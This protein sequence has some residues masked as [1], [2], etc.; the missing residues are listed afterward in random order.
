MAQ[1]SSLADLGFTDESAPLPKKTD[2]SDL[3]FSDEGAAPKIAG[4]AGELPQPATHPAVTMQPVRVV[5]GRP[6]MG[7]PE[8]NA[9]YDDREA[10]K[11]I[12]T[13]VVNTGKEFVSGIG[14]V[15]DPRNLPQKPSENPDAKP[16]T[17]E[18][19][20]AA[21][22]RVMQGA[23][24]I[25]D[26]GG[27]AALAVG[28]PEL[29]E[30]GGLAMTGDTAALKA[31]GK[32]AVGFGA[33]YGISAGAGKVADKYQFTPEG[34]QLV[35]TVSFFFPTLLG[36]GLAKAGFKGGI[37]VDPEGNVGAAASTPGGKFAAGVRATPEA[38]EA[39]VKVGDTRFTAKVPRGTTPEPP[40]IAAGETP[41]PSGAPETTNPPIPPP[42]GMAERNL[43]QDTVSKVA[44]VIKAAPSEVQG[45]KQAEAHGNL[46]KWIL[47]GSGAFTGPDGKKQTAETPAKADRLATKILD[48]ALDRHDEK[49]EEQNKGM[50]D[51]QVETLRGGEIK[52]VRLPEGS[53]YPAPKGLKKI[54]LDGDSFL[55][56]PKAISKTTLV[57]ASEAGT[58]DEFTAA[59]KTP[60]PKPAESAKPEVSAKGNLMEPVEGG[61]IEHLPDNGGLVFH[62]EPAKAAPVKSAAA[63]PTP[64]PEVAEPETVGAKPLPRDLAGSKPRYG[65]KDKNFELDFEDPRDLAAYTTTQAKPNKAHDRFMDYLRGQFPDDV[66]IR[67]HGQKV[68]DAIKEM[69]KDALPSDGPL[70]ISSQSEGIEHLGF[71][72]EKPAVGK[73]GDMLGAGETRLTV[74]GR[75]TSPFPK[76]DTASNRKAGNT[77]KRVDQW[78]MDNAIAEAKARGDDFNLRQ[79]EANRDRP[80]P[81]DKDSA[82]MYLFDKGSVQATP[83]PFLEPAKV[84]TPLD[85]FEAEGKQP[86]DI[87]RQ[88]WVEL[89]RAHRRTIGQSEES[90]TKAAPFSDYEEYHRDAVKE[91]VKR[92]ESV[93]DRVLADYPELGPNAEDQAALSEVLLDRIREGNMPKDNNALRA[94]VSEYDG[95]PADQARMKEA[96]E[97]MEVAIVQRAREVVEEGKDPKTTFDDL[98]GLY[99]SQPN[100]NIRTTTSIENQAYSTPAPLAFIASELA[101]INAKTR[102]YEPTAGNGMLLIGANPKKVLANELNEGR[103]DAL[104]EQGFKVRHGNALDADV[105]PKSMD[106]VITNPPFGSVKG[107][108][109]KPT[110]VKVDG[111]KVG[112][113]DHLI[114]V[115]ALDAMKD[116]GKASI[117][118]G[119]NKV[120]GGLSTDDR[121]FFNWLYSHY[122]VVSHFEVDGALYARQGANWPV[123]VINIDGRIR[124]DK[125]SPKEGGIER[126]GTWEEVYGQFNKGL[127][128]RVPGEG[129]AGAGSVVER[130]AA[131]DAATVSRPAS[132]APQAGN[133][134][135]PPAGGTVINWEPGAQ[136]ES[137]HGSDVQS[138]SGLASTDNDVRPDAG[139]AR[140][141]ILARGGRRDPPARRDADARR[142]DRG[143]LTAPEN[144]FQVAYTPVSSKK[145]VGIL[146]PKNMRDPLDHAMFK[147]E[148][149]VGDIDEFVASEL[150]YET[151]DDLHDVFMGLQI[152]SVA[153]A[154]HQMRTGKAVVISDM[155]GIGKGR[156][157]A[158]I[159]RWAEKHGKLPIFMTAKAPLFTDIYGDLVDIGSDD[160]RP[161]IVNI[162]EEISLPNG[163]KVFGNTKGTHRA[164]IEKIRS[165]GVLP[166][167]RNA[168]FVTYSQINTPNLQRDM[169][170]AIAHKAVLIMDES[171]RAAGDSATGEFMR[172]IVSMADGVVYLSATFAK[173]PDN[174][175]LY[176]K[177]DM[178]Q[179]I[180]DPKKLEVA[181][182]NGGLP[183]QTIVSNNL[184][185]AGQMF[186][187]ERSY[188]GVDIRTVVDSARKAEHVK[189]ADQATEVLRAI[190]N[191]DHTFHDTY[192]PIAREEIVG[193][194]SVTGGGNKAEASVNHTEFTSVVHNFVRQILLAL[195]ADS[196]ADEAIASIKA[197]KKPLIAV[198][199]TMG[200]FLSEYAAAHNLKDGQNLG[201]FTYRNVLNRALTRTRALQHVDP[202]GVKTRIDV[203]YNDLDPHTKSVYDK[204]QAL[205]DKLAI[206]LPV[207]PIDW[208][209]QRITKAGYTVSEITGRD[210]AVNYEDPKNLKL[211]S[212]PPREQ[213][214]KTETT[215]RF[216]D[217][218]LDSII[219][220]VSGSEGISLHASVKFTDQR[221]RHMIV[222]QPAGDINIFMQMLG[223]IFRT[224]QVELP[225]YAI[226]AADLPAEKRPTALLSKKMKSLNA[227]TSSNT[228]SAT[229]VKAADMM[230]KYGDEIVANYLEENQD[231]AN[232]LD[233]T[234][235]DEG[236]KAAIDV[237]RKATGR[238]AILP[239]KVQELF[240]RD[241]EQQYNTYI[242]YLNDTNQNDLEPR[243]FDYDAKVEKQQV[244]SKGENPSSPFGEDS[245][246][247]EYSIKAQ[248][249]PLSAEDVAEIIKTNLDGRTSETAAKQLIEGLQGQLESYVNSLPEQ[250]VSRDTAHTVAHTAISFI[251]QHRIGSTLRLEVNG[252]LFSAAVTNVESTH[253][254]H[255]NPFAMSKINVTLAT[256][257]SQPRIKIPA[258]QL[259]KI[260]IAP[261][262]Q[263]AQS[264]FQM[265]RPAAREIAKIVTGNLLAAYGEMRETKGTI[266][267]FTKE[268]GTIEQ[269][270]LLPK[271]FDLN[272]NTVGDFQ[273]RSPEH[274]INYLRNSSK[275]E[276]AQLGV[277]SRAGDIRITRHGNGDLGISVPKSKAR[278]GKYFLDKALTNLT[279]DFVSIGQ[280]MRVTIPEG[281]E[282]QALE[283]ILRKSALYV[284]KSMVLEA[285]KFLPK[286]ET[287]GVVLRSSLFGLDVAGEA[288]AEAIG[289]FYR[290]DIAPH[291]K[292]VAATGTSIGKT[293]VAILAPR[294]VANP[295]A[296]DLMMALKGELAKK[297]AELDYAFREIRKMFDKMPEGQRIDFIDRIKTGQKQELPEIQEIAD[298]Y[299]AADTAKHHEV[300]EAQVGNMSEA[301]QKFWK[302]LSANGKAQFW[303]QI[304]TGQTI[305]FEGDQ[306]LARDG[307]ADAEHRL[308]LQEIADGSLKFKEDHFRVFWKVLPAPEGKQTS[309]RTPMQA[310]RKRPI[311]GDKGFFR[312]STLA[313]MSE[314]IER[315]GI[316]VTTNPQALFEMGQMSMHRYT[317]A[318]NM[319]QGLKENGL[320]VFVRRG[321]GPLGWKTINDRIAKVYFPASSGEGMIKGGEWYVEPTS[322]ILLNN[323]L[324]K[325][326]IR[327]KSNDGSAG[328]ELVHYI[329]S[330]LMKFK[331]FSTSVELAISPLHLVY[332]TV[333]AVSSQMALGVATSWN[334]GL[335]GG[336]VNKI[337]EGMGLFAKAPVAP[338][339][340]AR[341]GGSV[342]KMVEN[343]EEFLKTRRGRNLLNSFGNQIEVAQMISDG[344]MGGLTLRMPGSYRTDTIRAMRDA[345]A[346]NNYVGAL[347]RSPLA[348]G[349]MV[350]KPLFNIY[351]PQLKWGLF[352]ELYSQQLS[353]NHDALERSDIRRSEIARSVVN[354]V[355]NRFGEVNFDNFFWDN[356]YK[357][358]MQT[359]F[360]SVTWKIG[361][362]RGFT[363]AVGPEMKEAFLDPLKAMRED[364]K[365]GEKQRPAGE[366][367]IPK[368]GQN[369][370]WLLCMALASAALGTVL[371]KVYSGKYPWEWT[372]EEEH[373]GM[374]PEGALL[375]ETIHPR[376][377][378]V[379][380]YTGLPVRMTLP[381]GIRDFEHAFRDPR[382]YVSSSMSGMT[383]HAIDSIENR[384]YFN[385]YV[386]DPNGTEYQKM[387]QLFAYNMPQPISVQNFREGK[388]SGDMT[389]F[390]LG[391]AGMT[392]ASNDYDLTKAEKRMRD[393]KRSAHTPL[394]PEQVAKYHEDDEQRIENPTRRE[395]R[396]AIKEKNLD[397]AERMF[398]GMS[399]AEALDIYMNYATPEEKKVLFPLL[400]I[401]RA[402]TIKAHPEER[403]T[404]QTIQ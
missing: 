300:V 395:L 245:I 145:D 228:E 216:N 364:W 200:S 251:Q 347:L 333:E 29:L 236:G 162:D 24:Q 70:K 366:Y 394:T 211:A 305:A 48:D 169:L 345:W 375:L 99:E 330:P 290:E 280:T 227:N 86:H 309:P 197:G 259:E 346:K 163:T 274:I 190:V 377:G 84:E 350:M 344:F 50:I 356:T 272:D 288:A 46:V 242:E 124:S 391:M 140:S 92:G 265:H 249:K 285:E 60:A 217:G 262:Y 392:R 122:N 310:G 170:S 324:S 381:T 376:T 402:N 303:S 27:K 264:I 71:E 329:G 204:A 32:I 16:M 365:A 120:A 188:D 361:F 156:Q 171:H 153:S 307:D 362:W 25:I 238:L 325:D 17:L 142:S 40:Q 244:L 11:K 114:A 268:D 150:G 20:K 281:K 19:H 38:Y 61:H 125:F 331:N 343:A 1:T 352:L 258:T 181:M 126:V 212:V 368:L 189:L 133:R 178:G 198:E 225:S 193:G 157:A 56:D 284:T 240:Y 127:A 215:R 149:E 28:A 62:P 85:K 91:A 253:K 115:R 180:S 2:L 23:A 393:L 119:A 239:V 159:I 203:P 105:E 385:N 206:D 146:I 12:G 296:L 369:Q 79:F 219:L 339:E 134:S 273:M 291:L 316:P 34:K 221:P 220:N 372:G 131:D 229:S 121:I 338:F 357:S 317:T 36:A 327:Y 396:K 250:S 388:A 108:D 103:A 155:T 74:T 342:I 138:A 42:E 232:L 223:R 202:Q 109:G 89:Q 167:E 326:L 65:Y 100:L 39:G 158:A 98:V 403:N 35:Q 123:R 161:F 192:V 275:P 96:Q 293:L 254:D 43:T 349:S 267:S 255:G 354:T 276:A 213:K 235:T 218:R 355:E 382:S 298:I 256:T 246:Y 185:K 337:L 370:A 209:R 102:V 104:A 57:V 353:E 384:D 248:A 282:K 139:T 116:D 278:G 271:K 199:L 283:A 137:L 136:P 101:G 151:I 154:I 323:Y 222:A 308:R 318:Q 257:G 348:V 269:G 135:E 58:M 233:V 302:K 175:P 132:G 263:S 195:K 64:K 10:A 18:E 183:L 3:G 5:S 398:K 194:S 214:D 33:G 205:I 208:I 49:V 315:G 332:E 4:L 399:Y 191:A 299:R 111:Y 129:P 7:G 172:G 87:T 311:Q 243:T 76:S 22:A 152:D 336:S 112:Q 90:G 328:K 334:G 68:R 128:A 106:A 44:A 386:Y 252:D 177:T 237:A 224:G 160:I 404:L 80:S 201:D 304:E 367:F 358:G 72:E 230:N 67:E 93:P 174:M 261:L 66:A 110:K 320:R 14:K 130:Q 371:A 287:P 270:I 401:K 97:A 45:A 312:M 94:I 166:D 13:A 117:I 241:V 351:I 15:F 59:E 77:L 63:A 186:R 380:P 301:T 277:A 37:G 196:A 210:L 359:V 173:R 363:A 294:A 82:E 30:I 8:K 360:R 113:I 340:L 321:E 26:S 187:R 95:K 247:G 400:R 184:V 118:L 9:E 51:Q 75:E 168:M 81:A 144:D 306:E 147:L 53:T 41:A 231:L 314:G 207:S 83:K 266:I 176:F 47:E 52:A 179:A 78:L 148:D 389:N 322:A 260:T 21:K 165:T 234:P 279:G 31:I 390:K 286:K 295:D 55:Y 379:D 341:T 297:E 107:P 373:R 319:W 335:R 69:A 164:A 387:A 143:D 313:D 292:E 289:T 73:V 141:D 378:K 383:S 397:Y 182:A 54:T 226:L 6:D 374:S 88:E